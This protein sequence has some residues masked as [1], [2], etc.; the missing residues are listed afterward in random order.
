MNETNNKRK[1]TDS[2]KSVT[3]IITDKATV[4]SDDISGFITQKK[5]EK[6]MPIFEKDL[7]PDQFRHERII[8]VVNYDAKRDKDLCRGAVGFYEK[9]PGRK[10]PTIYTKE[11][12]KLGF[13][14]YP[15]LSESVFIADPCI[16]G[17]FIEIDEY[18]NYM[19]QV[20][21]NELTVIAQSLGAKHIEIKLKTR[22]QKSSFMKIGGNTEAGFKKISVEADT[23]SSNAFRSEE[24][25]EVWACTDF[26]TSFWNGAPVLP[27]VLYFKNE[28]DIQSLIQMVVVNKSKLT[29]RTYSM[30]A[31]SSSGVSLTEASSIGAS[32][33]WIKIK[34]G[35]T[36]ERKAREESESTLEYT[37]E[38]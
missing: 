29:K 17:N 14:F 18:F 19:K 7:V 23:Q 10:I 22:T 21:V 8:R 9:T 1:F 2:I 16:E 33:K 20:R 32:L 15:H 38:F 12:G 24:S 28:S 34:S 11:V 13:S 27:T 6:L 30:K 25:F 37:V 36:F 31:S 5:L 4:V 26:R 3:R 35:S